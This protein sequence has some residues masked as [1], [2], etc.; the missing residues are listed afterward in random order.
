[1]VP[2]RGAHLSDFSPGLTLKA[3]RINVVLK[4]LPPGHTLVHALFPFLLVL[5]LFC[6]GSFLLVET[7]LNALLVRAAD[8]FL[9]IH[10]F[11]SVFEFVFAA[12]YYCLGEVIT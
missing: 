12:R 6:F 1:M 7:L 3:L 5:F 9:V 2:V 11:A 8:P 4:R 10:F